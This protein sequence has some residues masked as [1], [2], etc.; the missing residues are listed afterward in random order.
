MTPN[1]LSISL[2]VLQTV[3]TFLL[4]LT[5]I[6]TNSGRR[7]PFLLAIMVFDLAHA[8]VLAYTF[9]HYAAYFY[10]YW[11]GHAVRSL[12][13]LGLLYDVLRSLPAMRYVPK[14]IGLF[15][16]CFTLTITAGAVFL[17]TLHHAN[18]FPLTATVLMMQQCTSVAWMSL[19][20]CLL[21]AASFLGLSWG[22]E[23]VR[24]TSGFLVMGLAAMLWAT[25]TS[26]W[27]H[28]GRVFD[29]LQTCIE[30]GVLFSWINTF[31]P[32]SPAS[33]SALNLNT[34]LLEEPPLA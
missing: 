8:A 1:P 28:Y 18:T 11:I 7:W 21:C 3:I 14:K 31:L 5:V 29:K 16:L 13:S 2:W 20:V 33:D 4:V 10:T 17:A 15:I 9:P 23:S 12:L 24:I 26:S 27:P 19:A 22:L 34:E 30:I 6:K 32:D 25:L